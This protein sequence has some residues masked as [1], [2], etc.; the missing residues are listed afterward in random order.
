MYEISLSCIWVYTN[1]IQNRRNIPR[2]SLLRVVYCT[3]ACISSVYGRSLKIK[4]L[5]VY[6]YTT[7]S[8]K[9]VQKRQ[10][11]AFPGLLLR[12][13]HLNFSFQYIPQMNYLNYWEL[14]PT[15]LKLDFRADIFFLQHQ[16]LSHIYIFVICRNGSKCLQFVTEAKCI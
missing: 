12:F 1:F 6:K 4:A 2:F 15:V 14:Y 8:Q 10:M 5:P 11:V 7:H 3:L 9:S 13:F 16:S